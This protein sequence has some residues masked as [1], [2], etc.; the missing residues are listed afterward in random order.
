MTE[1]PKAEP[2]PVA[3]GGIDA[4]AMRRAWDAVMDTVKNLKRTTWAALMDAQVQDVDDKTL[5]LAFT[6]AGNQKNFMAGAN[7]DYLNDALQTVL[8]RTFTISSVIVGASTEPLTEA[9]A[10]TQEG[11]PP[12]DE[13]VAED[14]DLPQPE[15]VVGGEDEAVRLLT[16]QLGRHGPRVSREQRRA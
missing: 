3:A 7:V 16:E 6:R 14:P 11:M 15:R 9:P 5:T 4:V 8:G 13:V 12:G 10:P 1:A 2:A